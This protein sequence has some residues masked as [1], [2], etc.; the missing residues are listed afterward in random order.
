MNKKYKNLSKNTLIFT[1]GT[2]GSKF[3]SFFL[4]PLYTYVLST[5]EYGTIDLLN[6]TVQ[7]LLPIFTLNIQESVLRFS[8]EKKY[9][10]EDILKSSSKIIA[11][12]NLILFP[13]LVFLKLSNIIKLDYRYLS[14]FFMSFLLG[15]IQN[16]VMMYLKAENSTK[17]IAIAGII[18]A[19]VSCFFNIILLLVFKMG[20]DGYMISTICGLLVSVI[21]MLLRGEIYQSLKK[22]NYNKLL[23]KEM[24]IYSIPLIANG[25]AWWVN[26]ASD[27][28]ILTYFCGAALNGIYSVSY[29]IPSILS[30]VQTVF[31]NAWSVSAITEFDKE[32]RDGFIGNIF[33]FYT[34]ATILVCAII[35]LFNIPIAKI[36]Y[37]K[38]FFVAWKY[39]PLLLV[40]TI[41][42]GFGLFVGCIFTAVKKTKDI[43]ASTVM[44]AMVNTCLNFVLIPIIG[45]FGAAIATLIG[46]LIV[47]MVRLIKLRKIIKMKV[48]WIPLLT[49]VFLLIIQSVISSIGKN[50]ILQVICIAFLCLVNKKL[51]SKILDKFYVILKSRR[52]KSNI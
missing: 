34:V 1:I 41:F 38:D 29:K 21:Y 48:D 35:M 51:I 50:P 28:Y 49:S 7:L 3:I 4:V 10:K 45:V 15:S 19:S 11:F 20:I 40:A 30:I 37:S 13:I 26:N 33:T 24:V 16:M 47:F 42:N 25:V 52:G 12:S 36:I 6:T 39:V 31:Y 32:D 23:F 44:G 8:L 9:N 14:F 22:G 43:S 5:S 2:F 17:V 18:H 46:Y 27:R